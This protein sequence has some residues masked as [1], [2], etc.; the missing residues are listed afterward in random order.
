MV[1][2][3]LI[4]YDGAERVLITLPLC[5]VVVP[6]KKARHLSMQ[7]RVRTREQRAELRQKKYRYLYQ[8]RTAHGDVISQV[9][10]VVRQEFV[11]TE[12]ALL[13]YFYFTYMKKQFVKL[14]VGVAITP[15]T[16]IRDMPSSNFDRI[17]TILAKGFLAG[18]PSPS[19][20]MV[21]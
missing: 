5:V 4:S 7:Q 3:Y 8:V 17:P 1:K 13:Q 2:I 12:T 21:M 9:G 11:I 10:R 18:F 16:H 15:V 6:S 20:Q 14:W 19:R